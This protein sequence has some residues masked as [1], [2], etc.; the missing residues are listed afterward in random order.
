MD[1]TI[2]HCDCNGFYASVECVFRPELKQVPMA[3][4]GDPENRRGIILAKNELAK[5]RG[6]QTAETIWAA[7]KKCPELRLVPPHRAAYVEFSRQINTIYARYTDQVE[8]FGIDESWLDVT[9]SRLLFGD[10]PAIADRLRREVREETGLTIS[11]GVSFNKVFAKLGS[12]YKK[13]DATTV[14]SREDVPRIVYPLPVSALLYVG[15]QA[16][17]KL[18]SMAI[19]T[20]GD[21]AA[22]DPRL[23][24]Q[25]F[26]KLGDVL[27][28]YACGLDDSPV[29]PLSAEREVKSVG[30]HLTFRRN[31][32]GEEDI[33]TGITALADSVATRLRRSGLKCRTV[34][35]L[36]K[37]PQLAS[38]SRQQPL[39]R[40]TNLARE[41]AE[42]GMALMRRSWDPARPIRML[43]LTAL[44]LAGEEEGEQLSL[45]TDDREQER[46]RHERLEGAVDQIRRRFG[47][48]AILPGSLLHNDLG[49]GGATGKPDKTAEKDR[50][51]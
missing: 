51:K 39:E 35:V 23:L 47:G 9:G 26:G 21:L 41:L 28:R 29:Q 1:R 17:R 7:K 22:A 38:I 31:L 11:V 5:K 34:Q 27:H 12:D 15:G 20:I 19:R 48:G 33:R 43:G 46:G 37:N 30:S 3:V 8:P 6:I 49:I 10:G 50:K 13:P 16:A 40:A 45:F 44:Q 2:L 14:I 25:A 36:I 18:E 4:C 32:L 42:A 24:A